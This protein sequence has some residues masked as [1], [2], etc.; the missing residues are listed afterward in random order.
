MGVAIA[1][2]VGTVRSPEGQVAGAIAGLVVR[3]HG[4]L[5][6]ID[7]LEASR[8]AGDGLLAT[9]IPGTSC[10]TLV[11]AVE[12]AGGDRELRTEG[13]GE[14]HLLLLPI[15]D[16]RHAWWVNPLRPGRPHLGGPGGAL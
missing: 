2:V 9:V 3:E 8:L 12:V 6:V 16:R 7:R 14:N 15:W 10:P 13:S 4:L 11:Q 5:V 1:Q